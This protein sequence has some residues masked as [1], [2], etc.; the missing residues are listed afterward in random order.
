MKIL[1][2]GYGQLAQGLT[3]QYQDLAEWHAI[4]R[5]ARSDAGVS[6]HQLDLF[7]PIQTKFDDIDYV[8][9]TA[10]P[11]SRTASAYQDAYVKGVQNLLNALN[12]QH[13][14]HFIY[15][16]STSVYAQNSGEIVDETSPASPSSFSGE[17]IVAGEQLITALL[18]EKST[19]VRFGGIYGNQRSRLIRDVEA[20][21]T[22][23]SDTLTYTNR[24]HEQ[25]CIAL[26]M[27]L[28]EHRASGKQLEPIYIATDGVHP[29]KTQVY[30]YIAQQLSLPEHVK[31]TPSQGQ[32]K[33]TGKRCNN[34]AL[35]QLGYT[36]SYPDY[37]DGY[38]QM[39]ESRNAAR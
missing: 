5:R 13:L 11:S 27:W 6:F 37:R 33:V 36:F 18:A 12:H 8:I 26:L 3:Q 14:T 38:K 9:Y 25:D 29:T 16:S 35:K 1:L 32:P 24:I 28:V 4:C 7:E 30:Q 19:C 20:G 15:V 34:Q 39:I 10:T 17:A 21:V 22:L 2:A 31:L 23:N